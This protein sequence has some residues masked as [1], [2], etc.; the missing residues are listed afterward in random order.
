[1]TIVKPFFKLLSLLLL[2]FLFPSSLLSCQKETIDLPFELLTEPSDAQSEQE[3]LSAYRLIL[4]ISSSAELFSATQSLAKQLETATDVPAVVMY[5]TEWQATE[6]E[7]TVTVFVGNLSLPN[8]R[9]TLSDFRSDDYLCHID[10]NTV[11]L[12]AKS[13]AATLAA[14]ERFASE[15]LPYATAYGFS[16]DA[17]LLFRADYGI[18][19]VKINGFDLWN[20]SIVYGPDSS[21]TEALAKHLQHRLERDTRY[22]LDVCSAIDFQENRKQ[23]FLTQTEETPKESIRIFADEYGITLSAHDLFGLSAGIQRLL[24][25]ILTPD[26]NG[27]V[28]ITFPSQEIHTY[29]H[30]SRTVASLKLGEESLT[31][32]ELTALSD[33][34]KTKSPSILSL[35][36]EDQE[37]L[38]SLA[39][40]LSDRYSAVENTSL[41]QTGTAANFLWDLSEEMSV[42]A[43]LYQI[44]EGNEAFLLLVLEGFSEGELPDV[45]R[46]RSLPLLVLVHT[47]LSDAIDA[48]PSFANTAFDLLLFQTTWQGLRQ[49]A[50]A[51]YAEPDCFTLSEESFSKDCSFFTVK[52]RL[53]FYPNPT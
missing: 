43:M 3:E 28:S 26:A 41:F 44:G 4:P 31:R 35:N 6:D 7:K 48:A 1:M 39:T 19:S 34:L 12:G 53:A 24:E 32:A 14:L 33:R 38:T 52:R 8:V 9:H 42:P 36:T 37:A 51:V 18:S 21:G 40:L 22:T 50:F 49:N 20:Y 5:D 27:H 11:L 30:A 2:L 23:I 46:E 13:E 17:E 10:G 29:S 47:E 15:L 25:Q 16:S 45:L